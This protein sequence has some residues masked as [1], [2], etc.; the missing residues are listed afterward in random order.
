LKPNLRFHIGRFNAHDSVTSVGY[1][2]AK[3]SSLLGGGNGLADICHA[4]CEEILVIDDK[5]K[6][7]LELRG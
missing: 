6:Q 2:K 5:A 4:D 7:I 1:P 3:A